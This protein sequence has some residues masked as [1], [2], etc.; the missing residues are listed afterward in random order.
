MLARLL[1]TIAIWPVPPAYSG[2][3]AATVLLTALTVA[4][5]QVHSLP[6]VLAALLSSIVVVFG[7]QSLCARRRSAE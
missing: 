1:R 7:I 3:A 5:A 4:A 2:Q 6:G